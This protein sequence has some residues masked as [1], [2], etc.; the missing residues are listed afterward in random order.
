MQEVV[1][2]GWLWK[3]DGLLVSSPSEQSEHAALV[4]GPAQQLR[5]AF[6]HCIVRIEMIAAEGLGTPM[7]WSRGGA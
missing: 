4:F 1:L 3:L 5:L 2:V 6:N 7:N